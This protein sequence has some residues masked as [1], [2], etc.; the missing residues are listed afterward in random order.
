MVIL[1]YTTDADSKTGYGATHRKTW[2]ILALIRAEQENDFIFQN[3]N[4][5]A[6]GIQL[7]KNMFLEHNQIL[8]LI[9]VI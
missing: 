8:I 2:F 6:L 9:L 5:L 4:K 1:N 7:K 3:F